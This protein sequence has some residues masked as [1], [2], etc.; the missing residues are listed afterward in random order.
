MTQLKHHGE[1]AGTEAEAVHG[2]LLRRGLP[3][4]HALRR[5]ML[6]LKAD[7]RYDFPLYWAAFTV[8]GQTHEPLFDRSHSE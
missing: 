1:R 6:K 5:S 7:P 3:P 2:G 4:A 8:T